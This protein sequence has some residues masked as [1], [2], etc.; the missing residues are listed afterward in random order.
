MTK[1]EQDLFHPK[2]FNVK[3]FKDKQ[4]LDENLDPIFK[5]Q[6]LQLHHLTVLGR[7]LVVFGLWLTIGVIS[8]WSI[9]YHLILVREY[10]TWSAVIYGLKFN[11]IPAMGIFICMGMTGSVIFW[12]LRNWIFGL[13]L[14]ERKNLEYQVS[15]IRQQGSSHPLWKLINKKAVPNKEEL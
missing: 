2:M 13:P 11:P 12:Q 9:R 1:P 14:K 3:V 7:W 4:G 6:I 8:L 10:F 5:S 15:K